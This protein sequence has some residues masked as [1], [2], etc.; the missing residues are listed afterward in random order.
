MQTP[1]P[2]LNILYA[3]TLPPHPGGSAIVG[4][5][6]LTRLAEWGHTIRA[7]APITAEALQAGDR[8]TAAHPALQVRRFVVPFFESAPNNAPPESYRTCEGRQVRDGLERLIAMERPDIIVIG[9]ETFAFHVPD[10]AVQHGLPS[11]VLAHGATTTGM[12]M[13]TIPA[14]VAE[15]LRAQCRRVQKIV[16]VAEHLAER[17]RHWG[18]SHCEVIQNGVDLAQ[19]RPQPKDAALL[20]QLAIETDDVVVAHLSN[21]K[22][23]KRPLDVV[24]SAM[25]ALQQHPRLVYLIVGDGAFRGRMQEI[26]RQERIDDRF[27]FVGWVE[28]E[29]VSD[30]INLADIVVMPS[31]SEALALVYLETL[32]CGRLLLASDIAAA[33]EVIVDGENGWL[34]QKGDVDEL[35]AKTVLAATHGDVRAAIG[36]RAREMITTHDLNTVA[37]AY[38]RTFTEIVQ[39]YPG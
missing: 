17:Y 28:H 16:L 29:A 27:R 10:I 12:L 7:L 33:R 5:Q 3:G 20:R 23:L 11:V 19:F 18:L 1:S 15:R 9:R 35:A 26:C 34:F 14:A 6:L 4:A 30:Y 2:C 21:M 39:R 36:R 13:G 38:A 22:D 37:M 32:A 31:E 8:F 25:Q 24:W